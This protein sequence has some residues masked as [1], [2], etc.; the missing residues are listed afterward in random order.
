ML[1]TIIQIKGEPNDVSRQQPASGIRVY[2]AGAGSIE[3]NIQAI[4]NRTLI[5][6]APEAGCRQHEGC[7]R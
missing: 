6:L 3:D 4:R 2:Q 1:S 5:E 7:A